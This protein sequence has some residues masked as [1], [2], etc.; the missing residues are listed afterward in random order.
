MKEGLSKDKL[1]FALAVYLSPLMTLGAVAT[2]LLVLRYLWTLASTLETGRNPPMLAAG[3][4]AAIGMSLVAF[5]WMPWDAEELVKAPVWMLAPYQI[6]ALIWPMLIAVALA[7][8]T[9]L[10]V[11]SV[12]QR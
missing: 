4:L 11:R 12:K 5:W 8:L 6:W 2:L 1:D 9:I 7:A 3:W 10:V